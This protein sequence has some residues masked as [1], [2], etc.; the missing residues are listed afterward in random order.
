LPFT[1]KTELLTP[2][3]KE[4]HWL[5]VVVRIGFKILVLVFKANH[6]IV[7][8]YTSDVIAKYELTRSYGLPPKDLSLS[9]SINLRHKI[10]EEELFL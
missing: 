8:L 7:P 3:L 6:A 4:L 10:M 9:R 2:I 1:Q 5:F